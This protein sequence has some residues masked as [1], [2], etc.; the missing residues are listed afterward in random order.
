MAP[1]IAM[2]STVVIPETDSDACPPNPIIGK[3][4]REVEGN[5]SDLILPPESSG[6]YEVD[7]SVKACG[8]GSY[9]RLDTLLIAK[10]SQLSQSR[11]RSSSTPSTMARR[12]GERLQKYSSNYPEEKKLDTSS[13]SEQPTQRG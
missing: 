13:R 9:F 8:F 5:P 1:T 6:S 7:E 3:H 4:Q 12:H 11:E 10:T 2:E